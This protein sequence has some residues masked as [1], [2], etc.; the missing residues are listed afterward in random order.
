MMLIATHQTRPVMSFPLLPQPSVKTADHCAIR[1]VFLSSECSEQVCERFDE[2]ITHTVRIAKGAELYHA[3]VNARYLYFVRSGSFK[4]VLV[5]EQG[6]SLVT[7]FPMS[8][9][10]IGLEAITGEP[11]VCSAVALEDSE[12]YM[13]SYQRLEQLAREVPSLRLSLSRMLSREITQGQSRLYTLWHYNAEERLAIFMLG[14]SKRFAQRGY[15]AHRFLLRMSR[16][17]I[18]LSIGV[19]SETICRAIARLREMSL[20]A[21]EGRSVEIMDLPLLKALCQRGQTPE[22]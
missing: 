4:T 6:F 3:G 14:L 17:D 16:E 10:P 12:V 21:V 18:A 20:M 19:R 13:I 7:G 5:G 2:L 9:E 1:E 11:H 8:A 22:S 15:S